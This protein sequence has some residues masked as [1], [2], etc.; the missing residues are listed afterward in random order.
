MVQTI[1]VRVVFLF[2]SLN[3]IVSSTNLAEENSLINDISSE[4]AEAAANA[5]VV[6]VGKWSKNENKDEQSVN[7][8]LDEVVK[9]SS[10]KI[11][12]NVKKLA[13]TREKTTNVEGTPL[14]SVI[15]KLSGSHL[16][17]LTL[18]R[19]NSLTTGTK[20]V[21]TV[22]YSDEMKENNLLEA[23]SN[24]LTNE[25]EKE[26]PNKTDK[27]EPLDSAKTEGKSFDVNL[28][29]L[30]AF[31][32]NIKGRGG[33]LSDI[34]TRSIERDAFVVAKKMTRQ[35]HKIY[36]HTTTK[37]FTSSSGESTSV[38]D[39]KS[40]TVPDASEIGSDLQGKSF[41]GNDQGILDHRDYQ[42]VSNSDM[43]NREIGKYGSH[44]T[45][46]FG[47]NIKSPLQTVSLNGNAGVS[48]QF[49]QKS[50]Y[51]LGYNSAYEKAHSSGFSTGSSS[52]NYNANGN[53]HTGYPCVHCGRYD[54]ELG[55]EN[56]IY[57][58]HSN[59]NRGVVD[60]NT[61]SGRGGY[62]QSSNRQ[63]SSSS[64]ARV[65]DSSSSQSSSS[66]YNSYGNSGNVNG[67]DSVVMGT[68]N[69]PLQ[70]NV[71]RTFKYGPYE[72]SII[73]SHGNQYRNL[74]FGEKGGNNIYSSSSYQSAMSN[75]KSSGDSKSSLSSSSSSYNYG[76][77]GINNLYDSKHMLN[78]NNQ[79]GTSSFGGIGNIGFVGIGNTG[80]S[81]YSSGA[82]IATKIASSSSKKAARSSSSSSSS[83]SSG[84]LNGYNSKSFNGMRPLY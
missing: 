45:D 74:D 28:A 72:G 11:E 15:M 54:P 75:K 51:A 8:F 43:Q 6:L 56:P 78:G 33:N 50:Q 17:R 52:S 64:K 32:D 20:F 46:G 34:A 27:V 69:L 79:E 47:T 73:G 26:P 84:S 61:G 31:E 41:F 12:S 14:F 40:I 58:F 68:S 30:V 53:S 29:D 82:G 5:G 23:I 37:T 67:L 38:S 81:G 3:L 57:V 16:K 9:E 49:G 77:G 59:V 1:S 65:S 76:T 36:T 39:S 4:I 48:G 42:I 83:S 19:A 21:G 22:N 24:S 35:V 10:M 70:S 55:N 66:G 44:S 7:K 80:F 25:Y 60:L 71:H 62:F 63:Q 2:L 13:A 18:Q